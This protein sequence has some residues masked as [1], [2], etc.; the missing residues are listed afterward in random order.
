ML[1]IVRVLDCQEEEKFGFIYEDE[2]CPS[3][4][5]SRRKKAWIGK[6]LKGQSR[7]MRLKRMIVSSTSRRRDCAGSIK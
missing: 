5:N 2:D 1:L 6:R 4:L 3:G 7:S